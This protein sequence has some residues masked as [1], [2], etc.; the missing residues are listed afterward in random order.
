MKI[1]ED[2]LALICLFLG[3]FVPYRIF[4]VAEIYLMDFVLNCP[5]YKFALCILI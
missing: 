4:Y 1:P 2:M 3:Q 5:V